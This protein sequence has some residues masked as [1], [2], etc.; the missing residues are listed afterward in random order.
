MT[1]LRRGLIACGLALA[2]G[3]ST[4]ACGSNG[5]PPS[6]SDQTDG[7]VTI[8]VMG[9]PPATNA[10][11]R[12]AFLDQVAA[13]E[14]A[15]PDIKIKP[16]D[17]PW[18]VKTFAA[19]MAGGRAET[20]LKIPLTEP[21]GL[22]ER[23]QV[24][25]I[26][27]EAKKLPEFASFDPK[28]MEI[29]SSE[30]KVYGLPES[31]YALGLVYNRKLFTQA[32][33]DPDDPPDTWEEFRHAA[34]QIA[35]KTGK[36]GYGALTTNNSG[37]WHLTAMT[38]ANGG[39]MQDLVDGKPTATFNNAPTLEALKLL[40]DMRF[41]DDS[42]GT[43]QLRK[44]E[45][46][47]PAFAAGEIG[48]WINAPQ[49]Y[50]SYITLF[51]G[52]PADFGA[53]SLPQGGGD[54]T[55]AGG[56]VL[57]V[58]AKASDA[59]RAAAVK[60]IEY[61]SILPSYDTAAAVTV[62]KARAADKL[63]VGVPVLP[64]FDQATVDKVDAA[65]KPYVNVP[66]EQFAPYVER[67]KDLAFVPEPAIAAQDLY[68]ALDPVVQAVLTNKDADPAALLAAAEDQVNAILRRQ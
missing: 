30:G 44:G 28:V 31:I 14:K 34:D 68:A 16:S 61:S 9:L 37:G 46:A 12:Q 5:D 42:M 54:G 13:F 52:D 43:Q 55:L 36:I 25:D 29:L 11:S 45:D 53:A 66:T 67:T 40:H 41:V 8:S 33:L 58:T 35:E 59:E 64:V 56:T 10:E 4:A 17:A 18:D 51:K 60:W 2:L 47:S 23:K 32:G 62:A 24:A 49:A 21:P 26:T 27:V 57:M 6:T 39:T 1:V 3:V 38:Y 63:P 19:K 15:N 48:M 20:V 50:N 22:I 7:Q 65:I